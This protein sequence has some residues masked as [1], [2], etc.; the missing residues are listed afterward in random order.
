MY[1]YRKVNL[2]LLL[3]HFGN[4][5]TTNQMYL[6]HSLSVYQPPLSFKYFLWRLDNLDKRN[7][8][9]RHTINGCY[10]ISKTYSLH[11]TH[12]NILP[13]DKCFLWVLWSQPC[14]KRRF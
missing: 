6:K 11:E 1:I 4:F 7:Q 13:A 5:S 12:K 9:T 10:Q 14:V 8:A 3:L 2:D